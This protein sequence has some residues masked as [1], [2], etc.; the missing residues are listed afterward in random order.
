[1][2]KDFAHDLKGL[3]EAQNITIAEISAQTRINPKFLNMM[4][5][6]IFDFQPETYIRSFLKEYARCIGESENAVLTDYEKAKS[7][8]Y[9]RKSAAGGGK[10]DE[11]AISIKPVTEAP[12]QQTEPPQKKEEK[13]VPVERKETWPPPE[14]RKKDVYDDNG[15]E[16]TNKT[17]TQKVLLGLLIIVIVAGIV[18]LIDYLNKSGDNEN[19]NVKPKSFSEISEDYENKI[20]GKKPDTNETKQDSLTNIVN[21]SLKLTII[22]FRD[23]RIKV[24]I[25]EKR[26]IEDIIP[27]KDSMTISAKEQFRF[28]ASANASIDLYLNGEKLRKPSELSGSTSIKNLVINKDGIVSE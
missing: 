17:L 11:P 28:S 27:A 7:G 12:I 3:R 1:M 16:F 20:K 8:F 10:K 21:D 26:I 23:V 19:S 18:Y 15:K 9:V 6:G 22:T 25:D 5:S 2:L 13:P 4:E 24:Y 14:I